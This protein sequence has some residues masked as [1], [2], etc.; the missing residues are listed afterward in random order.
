ML[1][2]ARQI[3]GDECRVARFGV[4]YPRR[5]PGPSPTVHSDKEDLLFCSFV[6]SEI[7]MSNPHLYFVILADL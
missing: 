2:L 5:P 1:L 6:A 7:I 4:D 3:G